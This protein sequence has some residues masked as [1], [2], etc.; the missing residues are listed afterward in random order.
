MK[1]AIMI[2]T[3]VALSAPAVAAPEQKTDFQRAMERAP[4]DARDASNRTSAQA[5]A[6]TSANR[7]GLDHDG[8]L[9]VNRTTS[10]GGTVENGGATVN[11][12][13]DWPK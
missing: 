1:T 10:V 7:A 12:R 11:V 13:T 3:A 5:Q 6:A 4:Q 9:P 8:R 2:A